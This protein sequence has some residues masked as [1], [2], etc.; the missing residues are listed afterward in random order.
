MVC[1]WFLG[2]SLCFDVV[3]SVREAWISQAIVLE[4][5]MIRLLI[6][7][8]LVI[9]L[10]TSRN[11]QY[12]TGKMCKW[13]GPIGKGIWGVEDSLYRGFLINIYNAFSIYPIRTMAEAQIRCWLDCYV[14]KCP[15][16]W[17]HEPSNRGF[18]LF[19]LS[20]AGLYSGLSTAPCYVDLHLNSTLV[21]VSWPCMCV[22]SV[23]A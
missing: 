12:N 9:N 21:F 7:I 11:L 22:H 15:V 3:G 2:Q 6:W 17:I 13:S 18:V 23:C 20:A 19:E 8:N 14:I 4:V 16:V 1:R 5:N 10:V